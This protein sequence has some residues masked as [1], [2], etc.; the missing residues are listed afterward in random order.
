MA[1]TFT[2]V[3][4]QHA[5]H[6]PISAQEFGSLAARSV[7]PAFREDATQMMQ[8]AAISPQDK[9]GY[10]SMDISDDHSAKEL[11]VEASSFQEW[12]E[13]SGWRGS[14]ES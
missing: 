11:G 8:W 5:Y 9:I 3:T 14:Q 2:R 13:R 7:G 12:L 10:G 1:E 6:S 4:G